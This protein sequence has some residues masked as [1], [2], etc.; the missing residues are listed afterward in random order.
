MMAYVARFVR[1]NN[2]NVKNLPKWERWSNEDGE[3]KVIVFDATEND[4]AIEMIP[5]EVTIP[6][7][8]AELAG[9]ISTWNETY[10]LVPPGDPSYVDY[11]AWWG[12]I[13]WVFVW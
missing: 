10:N 6:G 11:E 4:I 3:P 12:T 13:P 8:Q 2:P 5:E 1:T 9:V 7:I